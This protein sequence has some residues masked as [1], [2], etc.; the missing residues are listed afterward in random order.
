MH[1]DWTILIALTRECAE[2][3]TPIVFCVLGVATFGRNRRALGGAIAITI[4]RN[5]RWRRW[6][7]GLETKK[8]RAAEL[9]VF[10]TRADHGF[11]ARPVR[12]CQWGTSGKLIVAT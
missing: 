8:K 1:I 3:K 7:V 2:T 5:D 12:S 4:A 10:Q 9:V 11:V 6:G